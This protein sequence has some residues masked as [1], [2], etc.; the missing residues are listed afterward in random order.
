MSGNST[1]ITSSII[2]SVKKFQF[3]P[4]LLII[5]AVLISQQLV[6]TH[7]ISHIHQQVEQ[8]KSD[9]HLDEIKCDTCHVLSGLSHFFVDVFNSKINQGSNNSVEYLILNCYP[10][11][12]VWVNFLSR[13][14]PFHS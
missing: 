14:P 5:L 4:Q 2:I 12:F 6:F 1:F 3:V 8:S 9:G 13:A 7:S 10:S 11:I